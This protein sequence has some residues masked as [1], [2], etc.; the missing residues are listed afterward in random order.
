VEANSPMEIEPTQATLPEAK[1]SRDSPQGG[2]LG[3]PN[4]EVLE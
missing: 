3:T 2:I 4:A 1:K